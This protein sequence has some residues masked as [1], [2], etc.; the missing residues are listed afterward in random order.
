[1]VLET[2]LEP[3][4]TWLPDALLSWAVVTIA[5]LAIAVFGGLLVGVVRHGPTTAAR[6]FVSLMAD[7]GRDWLSTSPRRVW[8]LAML[9]VRESIRNRIVV[10]LA[11][12]AALL[13]FAGWFLTGGDDPAKL[14]IES[15]FQ[16]TAVLVALVALLVAVFS[17]PNDI[18]HRTIY[19][20]V[21]KPVRSHEIILGRMIGFSLVAAGMLA[22][23]ALCGYV[24]IGRMLDHRHE[25]NAAAF[26]DLDLP[27]PGGKFDENTLVETGRLSVSGDHHHRFSLSAGGIGVA[28]N[29]A[30][31]WHLVT[32]DITPRIAGARI[33]PGDATR[34]LVR[35][36]EPMEPAIAA[37]S[38][39]YRLSGDVAIRSSSASSDNRVVTLVLSGPARVGETEV[40]VA[41]AVTSRLG[42]KLAS[43]DAV[44]VLDRDAVRDV[45]AYEVGPPEDLLR[46]RVPTYGAL[47]F[48]GAD[49]QER[50][51]GISVG[52]VWEYRSYIEGATQASAIWAFDDVTPERFGDFLRLELTVRLFRTH[53]G[54]IEQ[55]TRG[56]IQLRNPDD[57]RII[58]A[59]RDFSSSD[60][61]IA[62]AIFLRDLRGTSATGESTQLDLFDDLAPNGRLE[63]VVKCSESG[64]FF[65]M[66]Q[67]DAY[68][69]ARDASYGW[70]YAKTTFALLLPV[71]LVVAIAVTT[72]TVLSS[73]VALLATGVMLI[74]GLFS[75]FVAQIA[76]NQ[77]H[78]GGPIE[79]AY[80]LQNKMNLMQKIEDGPARTI[81]EMADDTIRLLLTGVSRALPDLT[82]FWRVDYLSS[83]FYI[84]DEHLAILTVKTLG[85]IVPLVIAGYFLLKTREV[86]A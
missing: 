39:N 60:G 82:S 85:Y 84:P 24:F 51:R 22:V 15:V 78:G 81:I 47:R 37:K 28:E 5:L 43:T 76:A 8:A 52:S 56:T 69:L 75:D 6:N 36:T 31:H 67:A 23:M 29:E 83:G 11:V 72:S 13:M 19:T 62:P 10:A 17:L 20:V 27:P 65:G 16:W 40:T 1:V 2:P 48:T 35:F 61:P 55:T 70:N 79:A 41:E 68:L 54:R 21:T 14:Y 50:M 4:L 9:A 66:A 34:V 64:Q 80:R 59:P 73:P 49:G 25:I 45:S 44:K 33:D 30:G 63:V 12:F 26:E 86:A 58:T 38:E 7:A 46:A 3:L 53:K 32:R 71:M 42:R 77:L 74:C 18:K 57:P